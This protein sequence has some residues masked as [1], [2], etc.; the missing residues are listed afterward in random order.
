[1][2]SLALFCSI[3]VLICWWEIGL[4]LNRGLIKAQYQAFKRK[5]EKNRLPSPIFLFDHVSFFDA[6][7]L[8]YW[9]LVWSTYSLIDPRWASRRIHRI[10]YSSS[11]FIPMMQS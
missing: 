10:P 8:K 2:I 9:A 7:S 11:L 4:F 3:N 5:L 6:I 1:M